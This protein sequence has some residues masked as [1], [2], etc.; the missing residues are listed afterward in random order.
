[1]YR[2]IKIIPEQY[3]LQRIF[4]RESPNM[5]LKE[6][7]LVVVTYGLSSSPYLAVRAMIQG[8][9]ESQEQYP[10]AAHAIKNDFYMDDGTTG[11]ETESEVIKLAK[12]M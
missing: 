8:A 3:E 6:Y 12:D 2:Q 9:I 5:P 10:D 4:W 7:Y 11:A 1:M